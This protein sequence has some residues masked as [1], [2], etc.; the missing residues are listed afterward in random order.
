MQVAGQ[1]WIIGKRLEIEGD[2]C[3]LRVS[4]PAFTVRFWRCISRKR[5]VGWKFK[6][7]VTKPDYKV[8]PQDG[9]WAP[10]RNGAQNWRK[11]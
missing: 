2:G 1:C 6:R 4:E 11:R 8:E 9:F 10:G 7:R 5:T 3:S